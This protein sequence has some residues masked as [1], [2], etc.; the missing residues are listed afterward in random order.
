MSKRILLP[1]LSVLLVGVFAFSVGI[2]PS[3]SPAQASP[4]Q[5]TISVPLTISVTGTGIAYAAPDIAYVSVGVEISNADIAVALEDANSRVEAVLAA[6][7]ELGIEAQDIRTENFGIYRENF[8]GPEGPTGEG[9]FRV[10]NYLRVT[11]RDTSK[12]SDVLKASIDA[13]ANAI[14]GVNFDI[15]DR[16]A[17]E[18]EARALAVEDA[19]AVAE[20]L[21]GL[22]GVSV[23]EV[24]SVSDGSMPLQPFFS[25]FGKG[26]GGG[27]MDAASAPPVEGGSLGVNVSVAVVFE[28]VR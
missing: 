22:M 24:I 17:V 7:S 13:G 5:Q 1:M 19:R 12:V 2:L 20:E 21:A 6:L 27:M 15:A 16:E 26:G 25:G 9:T 23:G 18:K 10:G 14:N 11:L 3:L 8:Y 4:D 28:L